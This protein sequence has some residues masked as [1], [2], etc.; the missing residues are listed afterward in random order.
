MKVEAYKCTICGRL[1]EVKNDA[2][3]CYRACKKEK[4]KRDAEA[5]LQENLST[6][7][8]YPRLNATSLPHLTELCKETIKKVWGIDAK[9]TIEAT[10]GYRPDMS[11][12]HAAPIGKKTNWLGKPEDGPTHYPGLQGRVD[13]SFKESTNPNAPTTA[14][15][16]FSS[17]FSRDGIKGVCVHSGSGTPSDFGYDITLFLDDFPL[18]KESVEA[19]LVKERELK[20]H[21]AELQ[22]VV[23]DSISTDTEISKLIL[24]KKELN[25]QIT[26]LQHSLYLNNNKY[27]EIVNSRYM[28]SCNKFIKSAQD[29]F[30]EWK[31]KTMGGDLI[32]K[33]G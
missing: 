25:T 27:N 33:R 30:R 14:G 8:N 10:N 6:L 2:T 29:D 3:T 24:A 23:T 28:N 22:G 9:L 21:I 18:L 19:V 13:G 4:T 32:P 17:S 15:D 16:F 11:C 7:L 5:A 31:K 26:S 20:E 1:H 12:S